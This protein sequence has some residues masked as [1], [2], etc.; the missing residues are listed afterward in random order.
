MT[1]R[2][3][4]W[5]YSSLL[6]Q[7]EKFLSPDED[8]ARQAKRRRILAAATELISIHGYRKVS[9]D[10]IARRAHV[11]KGTVYLYYKNKAEILVHAIA[12]EK[13][14]YLLHLKP[15]LDKELEPHDRIKGFIRL[16]LTL[17]NEMPIL[18]KLL[19]GDR[20][21]LLVLEEMD[22]TLRD[23]IIEKRQDFFR[24]LIH[25]AAGPG[26]LSEEDEVDR[27]RLLSSLIYSGGAFF[28]D[29]IRHGLSIERFAEVLADVV[30]DGLVNPVEESRSATRESA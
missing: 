21:V 27:A 18:S 29:R 8:E 6:E 13:M 24:H 1:T 15:V 30:V 17:A 2:S 14:R 3:N 7:G 11:A 12:E 23:E 20:E 9:V 25:A 4:D 28:D 10:E 22:A 26:A 16:T 19:Q 5:T